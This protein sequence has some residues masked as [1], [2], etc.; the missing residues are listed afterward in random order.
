MGLSQSGPSGYPYFFLFFNQFYLI[1]FGPVLAGEVDAAFIVNG[2]A[3]EDV[4][5]TALF[6]FREKAFAVYCGGYLAGM[7]IYHHYCIREIDVCPDLA[8]NP[9]KF[10]EIAERA[11]V[12]GNLEFLFKG[13]VGVQEE[14]VGAAVRSYEA[15]AVGGE[16]QPSLP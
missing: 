16:A 10:I 4:C 12:K 9:F 15:F 5:V 7:G 13:E 3:V 14:E 6:L 2:N 11:A 8:V 1:E